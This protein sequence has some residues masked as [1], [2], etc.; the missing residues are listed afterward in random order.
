MVSL[1]FM[2]LSWHYTSSLDT[3][4]FPLCPFPT[5]LS[6]VGCR[7]VWEWPSAIPRIEGLTLEAFLS[8]H[9]CNTCRGVTRAMQMTLQM[10]TQ[11]PQTAKALPAIAAGH[12]HLSVLN[13]SVIP[14]F[15]F[16][17]QNA[18]CISSPMRPRAQRRAVS[19]IRPSE[20]TLCWNRRS[21]HFSSRFRSV[22]ADSDWQWLLSPSCSQLCAISSTPVSIE[23]H[24][25]CLW[26]S[27]SLHVASP[28]LSGSALV[29]LL[30]WKQLFCK[31]AF[32]FCEEQNRF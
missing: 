17:G 32:G 10:Q 24:R 1:A 13:A 31:E 18:H 29:H 4:W 9:S 19:V 11:Q 8:E 12:H 15:F 7:F 20:R 5:L 23:Q 21:F 16:K 22:R 6:Q 14:R 25:T 3:I 27:T 30:V 2:Q 26:V 28:G